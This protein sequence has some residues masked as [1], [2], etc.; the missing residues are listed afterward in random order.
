MKPEQTITLG[1]KLK[2][3]RENAGKSTRQAAKLIYP[4][5][6]AKAFR[7][8]YEKLTNNPF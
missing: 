6:A 1:Q 5:T 3:A 7:V 8:L 2:L 4:A